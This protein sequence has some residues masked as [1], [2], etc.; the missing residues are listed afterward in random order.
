MPGEFY[1]NKKHCYEAG[2]SGSEGGTNDVGTGASFFL[3]RVS[4]PT[5]MGIITKMTAPHNAPI[6]YPTGRGCVDE[7]PFTVVVKGTPATI[8]TPKMQATN[9]GH[10]HSKTDATV[11]MMAVVLFCM[12]F[13]FLN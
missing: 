6:P 9:P 11:R 4:T 2:G 10:P 13:S 7:Y 12:V 1:N 3:R 8:R 5:T